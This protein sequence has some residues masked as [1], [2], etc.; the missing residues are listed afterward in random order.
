MTSWHEFF[1]MGGYA[2]YVWP[3]YGITAVVLIAN[4]ILPGRQQRSLLKELSRRG[5]RADKPS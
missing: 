5:M 1:T 2:T 4:A 3:A